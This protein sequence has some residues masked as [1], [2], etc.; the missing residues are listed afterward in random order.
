MSL[1]RYYTREE[2]AEHLRVTRMTLSRWEKIVP[3]PCDYMGCRLKPM[4][5][6]MINTWHKKVR[7]KHN[8]K[9][10]NISWRRTR[11]PV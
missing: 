7:E 3:L 8:M 10:P 6:E 9:Q 5:I 4:S 11:A 1:E 2:V